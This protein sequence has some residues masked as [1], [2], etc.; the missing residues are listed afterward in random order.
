MSD[1]V[2][3]VGGTADGCRYAVPDGMPTF[4]V[5]VHEPFPSDSLTVA[6]SWPLS[7]CETYRRM[8]IAAADVDF[9]VYVF[10]SMGDAEALAL[11]IA[12]YEPTGNVRLVQTR[13]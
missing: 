7:R 1:V 13:P 3:F 10:G 6:V 8:R 2:L 9:F 5:P 12:S 4:N 11:M